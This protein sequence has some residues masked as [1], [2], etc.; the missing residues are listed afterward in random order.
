MNIAITDLAKDPGALA[1]LI[2]RVI[3]NPH[4]SIT[5]RDALLLRNA[6]DDL[7]AAAEVTA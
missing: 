4:N 6:V 1:A 7:R 3:M 5:G 2:D